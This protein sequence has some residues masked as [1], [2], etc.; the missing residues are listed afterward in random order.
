TLLGCFALHLRHLWVISTDPAVS[1]VYNYHKSSHRHRHH[2]HYLYDKVFATS[3]RIKTELLYDITKNVFLGAMI[4][5]IVCWCN[6]LQ[7][8]LSDECPVFVF[9]L[10]CCCVTSA[11]VS[12]VVVFPICILQKSKVNIEEFAPTLML[13]LVTLM[14]TSSMG[15]NIF[16]NM[17]SVELKLCCLIVSF[18]MWCVGVSMCFMILAVWTYRCFVFKLPV[19]ERSTV[20]LC[21]VPIGFL[22]QGAH[23]IQLFGLYTQW[24]FTLEKTAPSHSDILR[25]LIFRNIALFTGLVL[26][27]LGFYLTIVAFCVLIAFRSLHDTNKKRNTLN[28]HDFGW[29][30]STYPCG[31]MSVGCYASY[32]LTGWEFERILSVVY[33]GILFTVVI[34]CLVAFLI[35]LGKRLRCIFL[36]IMSDRD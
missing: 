17:S 27:G 33:A 6:V 10:W 31:T 29:W 19:H 8:V 26:Q 34:L 2:H 22:G 30:S 18:I 3:L 32:M 28:F 23:C 12:S 24:Y 9:V 13:P 11:L 16:V 36:R 21:F 7:A 35:G 4:I 25:G 15:H 20:F 14:V 1:L 5:G